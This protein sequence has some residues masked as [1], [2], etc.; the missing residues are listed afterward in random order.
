[1]RD[2]AFP[3]GRTTSLSFARALKL[4]GPCPAEAGHYIRRDE[5]GTGIHH[6]PNVVLF[7]NPEGQQAYEAALTAAADRVYRGDGFTVWWVTS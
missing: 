5:S 3:H 4:A 6:S 2:S 1:M 7:T